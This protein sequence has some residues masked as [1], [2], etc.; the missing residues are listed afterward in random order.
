[1][2]VT[3]VIVERLWETWDL[4]GWRDAARDAVA[5][6]SVAL[7]DTAR[8]LAPTVRHLAAA[9]LL[10]LAVACAVSAAL[11]GTY[12]ALRLTELVRFGTGPG[13]RH[14]TPRRAVSPDRGLQ[15]LTTR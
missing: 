12:R 13:A 2:V 8:L 14:V 5:T 9:A 11:A 1:V 7:L 15:E 6:S 10:A 3:A 4:D